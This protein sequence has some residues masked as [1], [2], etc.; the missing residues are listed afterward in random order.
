MAGLLYEELTV[1]EVIVHEPSRTVT[2]TDNVLFCSLTMN[3]QPLHVDREFARASEYGQPLVNGLFTLALMMGLTVHDTTLGTT[4]GNLGF[5][6]IR[7]SAPVFHGDTITAETEIK[8]KRLS[9]SRPGWGIVEFEHRCRNQ[10]GESVIACRRFG[11]MRCASS[12][13]TA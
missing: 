13:A 8:G 1:G 5:E 6:D 7:F 4:G 12:E 2:E 3:P 9:Q 10:R 11:L